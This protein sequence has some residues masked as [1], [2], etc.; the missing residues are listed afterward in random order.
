MRVEDIARV[1]HEANRAYCE[2][3]GDTSQLPWDAAAGWQRESAIA[4]IRAVA[5]GLATSAEEQHEAWCTIKVR[6]GWVYGTTKDPV[7][8]THPCL[9]PYD[10]LPLAQQVKDHLFRAIVTTLLAADLGG[11]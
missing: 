6:E 10:K 9:V 2:T 4:G 7:A 8:K 3:L 11:V 5:D 1:V